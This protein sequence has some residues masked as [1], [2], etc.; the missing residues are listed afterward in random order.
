V[1]KESEAFW[2]RK[3]IAIFNS[4]A[5]DCSCILP[6]SGRRQCGLGVTN[7]D[8]G[9]WASTLATVSRPPF[10]CAVGS[11]TRGAFT[12]F[13]CRGLTFFGIW[14]VKL[15]HVPQSRMAIGQMGAV[16]RPRHSFVGGLLFLR[17]A[18]N[19]SGSLTA[20]A[21]MR[22]ASLRVRAAASSKFPRCDVCPDV[23]GLVH[24][25]VVRRDL[26]L[27]VI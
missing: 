1:D 22:R 26:R 27:C 20:L 11:N 21:A 17:R 24:E 15:L 14:T 18:R 25:S 3:R 7:W 5:P 2:R 6:A 19:S 23:K 4:H 8:L 16:L 13:S 10:V 12:V 9:T